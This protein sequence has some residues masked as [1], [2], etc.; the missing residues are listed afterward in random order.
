MATGQLHRTFTPRIGA[1]IPLRHALFN[2]KNRLSL[3]RSIEAGE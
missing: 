3:R 2:A 1:C